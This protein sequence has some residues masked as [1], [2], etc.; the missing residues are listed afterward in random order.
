[1][2][3]RL[4]VG[5]PLCNI[6]GNLRERPLA[7]GIFD[8][9]FSELEQEAVFKEE[10]SRKFFSEFCKVLDRLDTKPQSGI[11]PGYE[12]I[13]YKSPWGLYTN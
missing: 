1:M 13:D 5:D 12:I 7:I 10:F 11:T 8:W 3:N 9:Q 6:D 4:I 2:E